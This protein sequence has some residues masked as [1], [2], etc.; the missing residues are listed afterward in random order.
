[1]AALEQHLAPRGARAPGPAGSRGGT[2]RSRASVAPAPLQ[3]RQVVGKGRRARR[4]RAPGSP[5]RRR[6]DAARRL[7]TSSSSTER[8]LIRV[9]PRRSRS[10]SRRPCTAPRRAARCRPAGAGAARR[11]G[12]VSDSSG[13]RSSSISPFTPRSCGSCRAR[14]QPGQ[15][16]HRAPPRRVAL[17]AVGRERSGTS[18]C[19]E[20]RGQRGQRGARVQVRPRARK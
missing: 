6:P 10:W 12:R 17:A 4:C 7:P 3:P 13:S 14:G 1:M 5:P 8:A 18:S 20:P 2:G 11:T 16:M 15:S 9:P 19:R